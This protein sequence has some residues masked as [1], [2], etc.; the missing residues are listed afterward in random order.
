M[1]KEI[2]CPKC[3][4]KLVVTRKRESWFFYLTGLL[5]VSIIFEPLF[6]WVI[7]SKFSLIRII[8]IIILII[9]LFLIERLCLVKLESKVKA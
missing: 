3:N 8:I 9:I 5:I 4:T 6:N 1:R 2:T 7:E